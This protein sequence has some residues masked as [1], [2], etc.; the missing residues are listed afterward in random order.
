M[1]PNDG[2]CTSYPF[3][4]SILWENNE[5]SIPRALVQLIVHG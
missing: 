1:V 3:Q 4:S 2:I 5:S